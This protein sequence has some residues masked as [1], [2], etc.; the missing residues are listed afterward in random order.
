MPELVL[1]DRDDTLIHDVPYNGDPSL[2]VAVPDAAEVLQRLRQAGIRTGVV[3]NQ[4][5]VGTGRITREQLASVNG[6]VEELLG[7]FDIWVFCPHARDAGCPCRKPAPGM[8]TE[9]CT[10]LGVAPGRCV[11]V[12]DMGSDVQAAEAAGARAILV[13]TSRTTPEAV[14]AARQ[15]SPTLAAAVDT[16]LAGGW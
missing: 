6:R 7:P 11:V 9:A 5:A 3:T 2:V 8:V 1:F 13:P 12:G 16:I 14:S 15:V 4:S 10:A